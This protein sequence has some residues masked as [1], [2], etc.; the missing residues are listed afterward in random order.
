LGN[1]PSRKWERP[2]LTESIRPARCLPALQ[3]A[4]PRAGHLRPRA[5]VGPPRP[6]PF[7]ARTPSSA[8]R[9]ATP[10]ADWL[11]NS[12]FPQLLAAQASRLCNA[13]RL[14]NCGFRQRQPVKPSR[15]RAKEGCSKPVPSS[16]PIG[17]DC[18]YR[19]V[20]ERKKCSVSRGTIEEQSRPQRSPQAIPPPHPPNLA[21]TRRTA[22]RPQKAGTETCGSPADAVF[23]PT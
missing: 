12:S 1:P 19:P 23:S 9:S 22:S 3:E 2:P 16:P 11:S 4:Q 20:V 8:S 10:G 15:P 17:A 5:P 7:S 18:G 6:C 21:R 13:V 14:A